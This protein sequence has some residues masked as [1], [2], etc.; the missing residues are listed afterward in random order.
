MPRPP[1]DKRPVG[2]RPAD[3]PPVVAH[4]Q[5]A[6]EPPAPQGAVEGRH[7]ATG[8]YVRV[9]WGSGAIRTVS[10]LA[11]AARSSIE[12]RQAWICPGLCDLQ[13]NGYGGVNFTSDQLTVLDVMQVARQLAA[14]GT[15]RF[16]A[17]LT[18][19]A[20][21]VFDHAIAVLAEARR[22][23]PPWLTNM[24]V[25]I[26]LEGPY[27]SSDDGPRGAHPRAHCRHPDV[28]ELDRWQHLAEGAI[29]MVTLAPELPGALELIRHASDIGIAVAL[30]H[31]Q[32]NTAQLAAAADAGARL[33]THLGNGAHAVLPR[34]P[35]YLWDQ[36]ADDRLAAS[37]IVDGHHLPASVVRTMLRTKGTQRCLLVSDLTMLAGVTPGRYS[38]TALGNV[39]VLA[40]GRLVVADAPQ[41][42]AG[43]SRH[44]VENVELLGQLGELPWPQTWEMASNHPARLIGLT[45]CQ[46]LPG[47]PA[48]L[49][50]VERGTGHDE[51]AGSR[52][53]APCRWQ[54]LQA[55][56]DGWAPG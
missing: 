37:L 53:P 16:L 27:I 35:N 48:H 1:D 22:S 14:H 32:A 23:G 9:T 24:L 31:L 39:D 33:S 21:E 26:H 45:E 52:W 40:D 17:T 54:V 13:V 56:I 18:T 38:S 15:T 5:A 43:A 20:A 30:G 11:P 12:E 29:R 2:K 36:L 4:P 44:L 46:L 7:Y 28:A 19:A 50:L 41:Y 10:E 34:H 8:Q 3:Q 55:W 25:G 47:Q 42:L 51:P 6:G 49:T